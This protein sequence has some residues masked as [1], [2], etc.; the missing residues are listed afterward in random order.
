MACRATRHRPSFSDRGSLASSQS[1]RCTCRADR[2]EHHYRP[3]PAAGV[4][5]DEDDEVVLRLPKNDR[6]TVS[7]VLT[8]RVWRIS[9]PVCGFTTDVSSREL[10]LMGVPK[11]FDD[12][13]VLC[14]LNT[15]CPL[16]L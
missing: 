7:L 14:Y 12:Y 11:S 1:E 9:E 5:G 16:A 15:I 10:E 13:R 4:S 6:N 8:A 2:R 3:W